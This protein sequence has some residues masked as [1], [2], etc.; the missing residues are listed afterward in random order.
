MLRSLVHTLCVCTV[1]YAAVVSWGCSARV[2]V[3]GLSQHL[4]VCCIRQVVVLAVHSCITLQVSLY[5]VLTK[6]LV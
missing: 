4:G 2:S 5:Q 6:R 3:G 1:V